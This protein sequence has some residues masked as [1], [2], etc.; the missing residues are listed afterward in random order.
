MPDTRAHNLLLLEAGFSVVQATW[1]AALDTGRPSDRPE[2]TKGID[3]LGELISFSRRELAELGVVT[4]RM[5]KVREVLA[6]HGLA[7]RDDGQDTAL[8]PK[9]PQRPYLPPASYIG[10]DTQRILDSG[11][12]LFG[13]SQM[14]LEQNRTGG[15]YPH[16]RM[17]IAH[18][19]AQNGVGHD[20]IALAV[21]CTIPSVPSILSRA[22]K[23]WRKQNPD[24]H[25]DV[26]ALTTRLQS[27]AA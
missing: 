4:R 8:P 12:E 27:R 22:K 11:C 19:L 16:I 18:V 14:G 23:Q 15:R 5:G 21:G 6:Q 10:P 13:V 2:H 7:L 17:V 9:R 26:T 24:L 25:R 1:F 20:Q 3:T